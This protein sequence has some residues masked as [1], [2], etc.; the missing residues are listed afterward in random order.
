MAATGG[1]GLTP[2]TRSVQA[3]GNLGPSYLNGIYTGVGGRGKLRA[4]TRAEAKGAEIKNSDEQ[5]WA[6]NPTNITAQ[7]LNSHDGK[8]IGH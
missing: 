5:E 4:Q 6:V 3:T 8:T 1:R 2:K 7:P